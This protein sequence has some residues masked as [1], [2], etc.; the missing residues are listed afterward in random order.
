MALVKDA[1]WPAH[2]RETVPWRQQVRAGRQEDRML[3]EV[4][5][6]VPP[7]IA[8]RDPYLPNQLLAEAEQAA[9]AIVNLDRNSHS[10]YAALAAFLVRTD[11][12]A[13]SKIEYIDAGPVDLAK[14]M[15]GAKSSRSAT[16]TLEAI[17]ATT[18]IIE[19]AEAG[20]IEA[21]AV[22]TAHHSLMRDDLHERE[23][24][25]RWRSMQNW[26]GGSDY[27]P[28]NALYVPPPPRRVPAL[29]QDLFHF[30][31]RNDVSVIVQAGVV[32]A[33]FESIH[34]FT[35]G[36]GRIGR[37]LINA[38]LRRRG[39]TTSTVVPVA[40]ALLA[41][42]SRYF[43]QLQSYREGD[44]EGFVS[45]FVRATSIACQVAQ[46][47]ADAL[48]QL[49]QRWGSLAKPR[50]SSTLGKLLDALLANPVV[51]GEQ[52][53]RLTQAHIDSAYVAIDALA[54]AGILREITGRKRDRVWVAH[55]VLDELDRLLERARELS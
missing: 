8:R 47:S 46:E 9:A 26:I 30:A 36:N 16:V 24:S 41:N 18:A 44:L 54:A 40:A 28:R 53:A 39:L 32:H 27:S 14:A 20:A 52:A 6:W 4:Q 12:L 34:P 23:H 17:N 42:R 51:N 35:D 1:R 45:F 7:K 43:D 48:V 3:T 5:V 33:Q 19:A 11:S 38:V 10:A 21:D 29:M 37:A 22:L 15:V 49:P 55:E 25:G 50:K 2:E 31:N 13:S